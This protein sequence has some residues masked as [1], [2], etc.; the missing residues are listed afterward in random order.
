MSKLRSLEFYLARVDRKTRF[1]AEL[2]RW[3]GPQ[4]TINK[5]KAEL[6][7]IS[8]PVVDASA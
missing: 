7:T 1:R 2:M 5:R 8:N 6:K 4:A 3:L